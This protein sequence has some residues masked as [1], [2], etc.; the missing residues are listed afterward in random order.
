MERI[1]GAQA[2][3]P[4]LI[5]LLARLDGTDAPPAP[6]PAARLAAWIDWPQAVALSA[7]L[8]TA[9]TAGM[10]AM[11]GAAATESVDE[12]A[13]VRDAVT[14]ALEGDRAFA[15]GD[16][17]HDAAFFRQRYVALQQVMEG[18]VGLSRK[19]LRDRL[20][21]EAPRLA[22]LVALDAAMERALGARERSLLG[23]IPDLFARHVE[24][25][26]TAA[27]PAP[28]AALRHDMKCLLL[29]ELELR[30]QPLRGLDAALRTTLPDRHD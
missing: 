29:A 26:S 3:S 12:A 9:A 5:G 22:R 18:E 2:H 24:R 11:P 30:L 25:R 27:P 23:A 10:V 15:N 19:R 17:T 4:G 7:A 21:R 14:A 1:A 28:P 8:E 16:A 20:A 13:R 6:P